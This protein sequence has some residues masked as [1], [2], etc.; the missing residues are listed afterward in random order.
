[1]IKKTKPTKKQT[2]ARQASPAPPAASAPPAANFPEVMDISVLA[3]DVRR[4]VRRSLVE[5]ATIEDVA[6]ML[7]AQHG[8]LVAPAAIQSFYNGDAGIARD[9]AVRQV[10]TVRSLKQALRDEK[11]P[12]AALAEATLL[13]GVMGL[14]RR[15]ELTGND[16]QRRMHDHRMFHL[17][18]ANQNMK[19]R[20][21]AA[22]IGLNNARR[23]HELVKYHEAKVRC[24]KLKAQLSELCQS[25]DLTPQTLQRIQEI[26]GIVREP[27]DP[28]KSEETLER[29]RQVLPQ[30]P[31]FLPPE[32]SGNEF[33]SLDRL[34]GIHDSFDTLADL[35]IDAETDLTVTPEGYLLVRNPIPH[36]PDCGRQSCRLSLPDDEA[37]ASPP[38][39]NS[40]GSEASRPASSP[41][42][43]GANHPE[44]QP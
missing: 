14:S 31:N 38:Y 42:A 18:E 6:D 36:D 16:A 19:N 2:A 44:E 29:A 32:D 34:L 27:F 7:L 22:Q 3:E 17:L 40:R 13:T 9:R 37:A 30:P 4:K 39:P 11:S 8:M 23:A 5:G 28:S 33:D 24:K 10:E 41:H 43:A 25:R 1:M 12:L 35:G 21:Y 26:Y 15:G 20:L